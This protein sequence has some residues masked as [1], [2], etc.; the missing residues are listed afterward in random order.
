MQIF[1]KHFVERA[2]ETGTAWASLTDRTTQN[3]KE[4]RS[5]VEV[6]DSSNSVYGAAK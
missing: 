2:A 6:P 3:L 4:Y 5:K 1:Q